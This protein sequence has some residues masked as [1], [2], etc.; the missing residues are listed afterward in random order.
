MNIKKAMKK[1]NISYFDRCRYKNYYEKLKIDEKTILIES[2]QGKEFG[3]NMY[4]ICKE[5]VAN[6]EYKNYKIYMSIIKSKKSEA[7]EFFRNKQMSKVKFVQMNS[8]EYF[9]VISTAKYLINDNTFLPFFIK[10]EGQIYLN[11]WHGT[12]LKSLGKKIRNDFHNIGNAQ[13]NFIVSDYLLFPNEYTRD[14]MLEDY[15]TR[16]LSNNKILLEGYPRNTAFFDSK[17]RDEIKDKYKLRE[18]QIIAYMPTWRGTLGK[19]NTSIQEM[20]LEYIFEEMEERLSDNQIFYVNLHPIERAK[21]DFS[22]YSK[23]KPFPV[24]YETY[25]FLNTADI[26]VTDYSSVF[27]DFLNTDKKIILY[28]YDRDSYLEDRGLY[29]QLE[30]LPFPI[31]D[32]IKDLIKEINTKKEYDDSDIKEKFCKYDKADSTNRICERVILNK[33]NNI[34]E[35]EN[36]GNGKKN[37]LI[38][39]GKLACNGITMSLRNLIAV[40]DKSKYNYYIVV[41]TNAIKK[42]TKQ[43]YELSQYVDYIPIKGKMNM[44][45]VQKIWF[46]MHRYKLI[47]TS[48][49]MRF[50]KSVYSDDIKR[51]FGDARIDNVIQFS[52]YAYKRTLLFSAF[53]CNKVIFS[54]SDMYKEATEKKNIRLDVLKY[55]YNN[56]DKIALVT[57][58]I[59]ESTKK[60]VDIPSKYFIVNNIINYKRILEMSKMPI[61][62]DDKTESTMELNRLEEVLNSS[63]K[64]IISIGRFSKEKGHQRLINAF[65]RVWM[66]DKSI[67]LI[68]VGGAGP[69]YNKILDQVKG[70]TCKDNIIIIKYVSNPYAILNKCDCL[71]LPSFYEGFGLVIAE[72]DILGKPV[73]STDIKGPRNFV[74]KNGGTLVENSEDGIYEGMKMLL[75]GQI[76]PMGVDYEQYNKKAVEQFENLL[77]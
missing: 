64:K 42:N 67:Y 50:A 77:E 17:L 3:G 59:L 4:Y 76:K 30:E 68:L 36:N 12:P 71:V 5:L 43:L 2:Q 65:E 61:A 1:I 16:N 26:L 53:K 58:D 13:K 46:F 18:K 56:Y 21:V 10:K 57:D 9:K 11:T 74:K 51:V 75:S 41:D 31:V 33:G 15:M 55:A 47:D 70:L 39:G 62:F 72:A 29:M 52:G 63:N 20:N 7:E 32:R 69:E 24:E 14:H 54:H 6:E 8:K 23:V 49:Y 19:Q 27:F 66:E 60:I 48:F 37:V 28:T 35:E 73:I 22:K 45:L 38:F 44:N 34:K 40:I 25:E